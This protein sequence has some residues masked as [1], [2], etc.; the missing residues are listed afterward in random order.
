LERRAALEAR[1]PTWQPMTI[2]QRLDATAELHPDRP[3]VFSE[4]KGYT[5]AEIRDWSRSL[6]A[7]LVALGI[8]P[9]DHVAILMANCPEFVAVKFGIA[10][11][12]AVGVPINCMFKRN[13][14]GY[15]LRQSDARVLITMDRFRDLDYL[16]A[17]DHIA[18]GWEASGGG[19]ALPKLRRVVLVAGPDGGR[20]GALT[21][22]ELEGLGAA[23]DA[24]ADLARRE[25]AAADP[26]APADV[27]YT[28]GTTGVPKGVILTHDMLLRTAYASAYHR[29]FQ[30]G[31]RIFFALPLYHVFGYVEAL[32]PALFV[33]GA[34]IP[35]AIFDPAATLRAIGA[36]RANEA[37][38]V[39]TMT[40]AVIDELQRG[41]YDLSSLSAVFS[42]AGQSPVRIW[43][44]IRDELGVDE[45]FTAYGMTETTASTTCTR[46]DDPLERL[47]ETNG[48]YKPA[49]IAGDPALGGHLALYKTI[50]PAT[51]EDLPAGAEG[52]LV[53]RGPICTPGYYKK[54]EETAAVYDAHGWMRTGDLGRI[55]PDGYLTL[56]GRKKEAYK[57]GGELVI[58]KEIEDV[59]TTHPAVGQAYV[60]GIPHERMG[61]VGCAWI[62]P[63]GDEQPHPDEL[64]RYCSERLA[65]F[66]VP[67]HVLFLEAAD[68]P[69]SASGKAQKFVLAERAV[70]SLAQ[71]VS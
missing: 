49:G 36:H 27:I 45:I 48:C 43:R 18:P 34:I 65:R 53:A 60:V 56:T 67:A 57:C 24:Q 6:A 26:Q 16:A 29:A 71:A 46:P 31:R 21:F 33:G 14:L 35:H 62:I 30:D 32:L 15:V 68:V 52:E 23:R 44:Q 66:K 51:G 58:P 13:E 39:P 9:G 40:M 38:F 22:G 5:Y 61:E 7:G 54:P 4:T 12:G 70:A 37:M 28:S 41:R 19:K 47:A 64:I 59:L 20:A 10:R 55:A 2:A 17:L 69:T 63:R 3:L 25:T 8:R 50:D 1:H 42:S 11:A